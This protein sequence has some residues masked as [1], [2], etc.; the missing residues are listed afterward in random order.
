MKTV[1]CSGWF[2]NYYWHK[3]WGLSGIDWN[4]QWVGFEPSVRILS[5]GFM[6]ISYRDYELT[7]SDLLLVADPSSP[8]RHI[9]KHSLSDEFDIGV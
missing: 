9:T 8:I 2:V 7:V 6:L 4:I 3:I 5:F 1:Q